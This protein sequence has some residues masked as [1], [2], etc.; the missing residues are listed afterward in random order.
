MSSLSWI[1][2]EDGVFNATVS[3]GTEI[4]SVMSVTDVEIDVNAEGDISDENYC[5]NGS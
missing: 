1:P 5:K 3:V 4:D 2:D